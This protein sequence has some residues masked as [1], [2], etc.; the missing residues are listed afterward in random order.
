MNACCRGLGYVVVGSK[1]DPR[2]RKM[3]RQPDCFGEMCIRFVKADEDRFFTGIDACLIFRS[4]VKTKAD[5]RKQFGDYIAILWFG[6]SQ[7]DIRFTP[8]QAD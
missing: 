4:R 1:T 7:R 8:F 6:I 2:A 5:R 3:S